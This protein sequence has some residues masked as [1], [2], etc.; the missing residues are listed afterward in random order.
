MTV[1]Y[2]SFRV[3]YAAGRNCMVVIRSDRGAYRAVCVDEATRLTIGYPSL[4]RGAD[5][6]RPAV[7]AAEIIGMIGGYRLAAAALDIEANELMQR[8]RRISTALRRSRRRR[9]QRPDRPANP[10]RHRPVG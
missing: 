1:S 8:S 9:R 4:A 7:A 10:S 3:P 6:A 2:L 5:G